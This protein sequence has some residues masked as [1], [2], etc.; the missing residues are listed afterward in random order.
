MWLTQGVALATSHRLLPTLQDTDITYV[1]AETGSDITGTGSITVPF[2]TIGRAINQTN[3]GGTIRVARGMYT[4]NLRL[5]KPLDLLGGYNASDW[6]SYRSR[7]RYA[8]I[9]NGSDNLRNH[10]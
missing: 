7:S 9:I 6:N 8:T 3:A 5:E 1:S 10:D 4:E 2:A